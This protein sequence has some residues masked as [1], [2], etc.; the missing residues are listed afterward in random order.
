MIVS[1]ANVLVWR[2]R[3]LSWGI[4]AEL[5]DPFLEW[6]NSFSNKGAKA[7]QTVKLSRTLFVVW[8]HFCCHSRCE[9]SC[10]PSIHVRPVDLVGERT[11]FTYQ[12]HQY[13]VYA[14]LYLL[15][16]PVITALGANLSLTKIWYIPSSRSR[17]WIRRLFLSFLFK[18]AKIQPYFV[19][20]HLKR[21]EKHWNECCSVCVGGRTSFKKDFEACSAFTRSPG[22]VCDLNSRWLQQKTV[23]F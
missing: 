3:R 6:S 7:L 8:S 14:G 20:T 19:R 1:V 16:Q 9:A 21:T 18:R 13:W 2:W 10:S 15:V 22:Q 11:Q 23:G 4:I 12:K 5:H 17:K